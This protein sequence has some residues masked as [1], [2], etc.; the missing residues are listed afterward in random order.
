MSVL[1]I[2]KTQNRIALKDLFIVFSCSAICAGIFCQFVG[3]FKRFEL[4]TI[5][6]R[7]EARNWI[8]WTP[9]SLSRLNPTTLID[10]HEKHEIPKR[11]WAWDYTLSWLIEDNHPPPA[12]KLIVFNR[13]LEDE[14]PLDA[15]AYHPWMKPL[16]KY[17]LPRNTLA[18]MV[19][20][21]ASA[22]ARA[23]VLDYDFPQ[24]TEGDEPLARALHDVVSKP[25]GPPVFM[26]N[27]I[28][29]VNSAN[30]N[31]LDQ[32][33][34][35][36][37]V[38]RQLQELEPNSD[39]IEKYTG[40]TGVLQD[41]D[42]V[43]RRLVSTLRLD[44]KT[45]FESVVTKVLKRVGDDSASLAPDV[46][47]VD[48]TTVPNSSVYPVRPL[49]YLLDPELKRR[50]SAPDSTDVFV[51]DAIV[52]IG[53]GISDLYD[54][55]L[56]NLGANRRSGSEL[57]VQ[58]MD[59]IARGSWLSRLSES[60]EYFYIVSTAIAGGL[61]FVSLRKFA[62]RPSHWRIDLNVLGD[63]LLFIFTISTVYLSAN[64][65]FSYARLIVP[66]VVPFVAI[67]LA[68]VVTVL[69]ERDRIKMN[70]IQEKL[71]SSQEK[72][73]L[74]QEK[75]EAELLYQAS[76][77]D[78]KALEDD[79]E[80]R[81]DMVRRLNHDLKAPIS[82]FN[83]TLAKLL[84]DRDEIDPMFGIF[85]RLKKSSEHLSTLL[86]EIVVSL[87]DEENLSNE[88]KNK[89]CEITLALKKQSEL[90]RSLAEITNSELNLSIPPA[91][92]QV[93]VYGTELELARIVDNI[94]GNALKHNPPGTRVDIILHP[95]VWTDDTV[96]LSVKDN[97]R[98]I[99]RDDL[100]MIFQ[101]GYRSGEARQEG[102]GLGLSIASTLAAKI[103]GKIIVTSE[104]GVGTQFDITF[105]RYKSAAEMSDISE[106]SDS[107]QTAVLM[108]DGRPDRKHLP[109]S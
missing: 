35:R 18:E 82:V 15:V 45:Q 8:K 51:K 62:A 14:P 101:S 103:G 55:P 56:T 22:G 86:S 32:P 47:D 46:F 13:L 42:Q 69:W 85:Q 72:L 109:R 71:K 19:D 12:L 57:L 80:R 58:G 7:F 89:I 40:L 9:T 93:W 24:V 61:F 99:A 17:P 88:A 100:E 52:V 23:I 6:H 33:I 84:K 28:H 3:L 38:I 50:I 78:R 37:G 54:T 75:H 70:S 20:F 95:S 98:G 77:A 4:Q 30:L 48:F 53:D 65:L 105:K 2:Q 73:A 104:L 87:S 49:S 31:Q 107:M 108:S 16:L 26:A 106:L 63:V 39:V 64:L 94:V 66:L 11:W 91:D 34:T 59:T 41:E 74:A 67:T 1:D 36:S 97:G 92:E 68:T 29:S 76:L 25:G 83:W 60:A 96:V 102:Q 79:R 10:Y 81:H 5:N 44:G 90:E 27:S 43:V 21:L